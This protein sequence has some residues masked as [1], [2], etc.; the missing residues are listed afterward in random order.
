[1]VLAVLAVVLA[2]CAAGL[3]L[4]PWLAAKLG[5]AP[6]QQATVEKDLI[7]TKIAELIAKA[8]VSVVVATET[9][10]SKLL[11]DTLSE[12]AKR[13]IQ[14][15]VTLSGP[16][17]QSNSPGVVWLKKRGIPTRLTR[18]P[19]SGLIIVTDREFAGIC[20]TPVVPTSRFAEGQ[21]PLFVFHHKP[22]AETLFQR[23]RAWS[24]L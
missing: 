2:A 12:A 9:F 3:N 11:L 7:P 19:F 18:E 15:G 6:F 24:C 8:K 13:N 17:N 14:I 23:V 10:D 21:A 4:S 16:A 5:F 20:A 22:T 1:M